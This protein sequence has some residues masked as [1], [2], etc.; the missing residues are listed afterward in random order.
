MSTP[1][2]PRSDPR[3]AAEAL[4]A[5]TAR[6]CSALGVADATGPYDALV[7]N[8]PMLAGSLVIVVAASGFGIL[9][10]LARFGYDAGLDPLS[11]V[12]WRAIFALLVIAVV[13]AVLDR[14]GRPV[15]APWRLPARDRWGI[16]AVGLAGFALYV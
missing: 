15:V 1:R 6:T 13:V 11:F 14:R 7:Q 12:A 5:A 8:R 4:R 3:R 2:R 10:P 9:G 16:L